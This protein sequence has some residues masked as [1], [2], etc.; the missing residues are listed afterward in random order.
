[1]CG[2]E[3]A[4]GL[5]RGVNDHGRDEGFGRRVLAT[6]SCMIICH[7]KLKINKAVI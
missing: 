1:M 4:Q 5:Q 6:I 3:G 2:Q 7:W